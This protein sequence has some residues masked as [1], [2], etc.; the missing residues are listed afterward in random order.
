MG[1]MGFRRQYAPGPLLSQCD[2][3]TLRVIKCDHSLVENS[4]VVEVAFGRN[5]RAECR[6]FLDVQHGYLP[7]Q[8]IRYAYPDYKDE[9]VHSYLLEEKECS[10]GRWFPMHTVVLLAPAKRPVSV[11]DIRVTDLDVDSRPKPNEFTLTIPARTEIKNARDDLHQAFFLKQ[12][13]RI[14]ADDIP[15]LF[16][17]L[18]EVKENPLADTSIK[19]SSWPIA[20]YVYSFCAAVL[21]LIGIVFWRRRT[22][23]SPP[24]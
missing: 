19:S 8:I 5:D 21:L 1:A 20:T 22:Y 2:K 16:K 12:E 7:R 14:N 11:I 17:K 23:R 15:G 9:L 24:R 6:F 3:G 13:E 10:R 4:P 18:Q